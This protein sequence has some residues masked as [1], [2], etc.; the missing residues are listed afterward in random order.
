MRRL[1][2]SPFAEVP[3]MLGL[4]RILVNRGSR[5]IAALPILRRVAG[6]QAP[7]RAG[8]GVRV[9]GD[10]TYALGR[11]GGSH[12]HDDQWHTAGAASSGFK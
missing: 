5:W 1:G 3:G 9:G 6:R 11:E 2:I 7:A 8:D 10:M 12:A 4:M